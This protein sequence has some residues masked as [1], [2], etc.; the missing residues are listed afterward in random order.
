[1]TAALQGLNAWLLALKETSKPRFEGA[2]NALFGRSLISRYC[3]RMRGAL[4]IASRAVVRMWA[5]LWLCEDFWK[6]FA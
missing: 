1:M 6:V 2:Q 3:R 4:M 5:D